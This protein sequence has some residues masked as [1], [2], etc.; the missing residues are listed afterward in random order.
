[1][2]KENIDLRRV[3]E[4][5]MGDMRRDA[6][7]LRMENEYLTLKN[8]E[9]EK[10]NEELERN[11]E[12][13][14]NQTKVLKQEMEE[15]R[16]SLKIANGEAVK[17]HLKSSLMNWMDAMVKGKKEEAVTIF[18]L[19]QTQLGLKPNERTDLLAHLDKLKLKK[20]TV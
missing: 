9:L 7:T 19:L 11:E 16:K 20:K 17:Q 13:Y 3:S 1:M 6:D 15:L 5:V 2:E 4:S 18:G 14:M 10:E 8:R 12:T